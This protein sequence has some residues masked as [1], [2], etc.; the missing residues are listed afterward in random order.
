M[1]RF[2]FRLD[3][4]LQLREAAERE[5]ARLL[6]EAMRDEEARRQAVR[7]S[8]ERLSEARSQLMGTP[9][10]LSQAGTLR[11]LVLTVDALAVRSQELTV[12]HEQSLERLE[13]ERHQFEHARMDRRVLERL[14]AQRREAWGEAYGHWEQGVIDESAALRARP[15]FPEAPR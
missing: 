13:L 6:G 2:T 9:T 7:E 11:N 5:R 10:Q 14:K 8:E 1:K 15:T 12:T 4:L 3:R